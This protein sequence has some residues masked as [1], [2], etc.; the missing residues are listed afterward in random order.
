V[1]R[2]REVA[3]D[4]LLLEPRHPLED[5]VRR[6]S[7]VPAE[8]QHV[9]VVE[10][11]GAQLAGK[12]NLE[13]PRPARVALQHDDELVA[14]AGRLELSDRGPHPLLTTRAVVKS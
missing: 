3:E 10:A 8:Q 7:V 4:P 6:R 14:P 12:P 9:G 1:A 11:E 13:Q 2:H 5:A